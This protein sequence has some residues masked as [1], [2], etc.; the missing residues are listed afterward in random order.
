MGSADRADA[1]VGRVA[2]PGVGGVVSRSGLFERLGAPAS[3]TV[4]SAP[5]GSGKT[6]LRSWI[7]AAGLTD[8]AGCSPGRRYSRLSRAQTAFASYSGTPG[9]HARA[10]LAF[11]IRYRLAGMNHAGDRGGEAESHHQGD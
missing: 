10:R 11:L 4:V 2:R 6:L 9:Q 1:V 8:R 7:G 3:V 5:P